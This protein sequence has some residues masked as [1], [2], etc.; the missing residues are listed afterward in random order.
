MLQHAPASA[1]LACTIVFVGVREAHA[2]V[3]PP[4][5]T[6]AMYDGAQN[7]ICANQQRVWIAAG[8]NVAVLDAVTGDR[9]GV[10]TYSPYATSVQAVEFDPLSGV[11]AVAT[12]RALNVI[13]PS[14]QRREWQAPAGENFPTFQ[15]V[16]LWPGTNK[17]FAI[18]GRKLA[19]FEYSSAGI[20]RLGETDC[21]TPDVGGLRRLHVQDV[22]GDLR[23]YVVAGLVGGTAPRKTALL[24]ADLDREHGY[25]A[26]SFYAADWRAHVVYSNPF[27]GARAVEV[28]PNLVGTQDVAFVADNYGELSVLDV[29]DPAQPVFV[30]QIHPAGSCGASGAAYNLLGERARNRLYVAGANR[31]Y[32]LQL[33]D[34]SIVGCADVEFVDAGR[35]DMALVRRRNGARILW[36]TTPHAATWSL[37]G[38]D[39]GAL[40]PSIARQG[41]WI[42]SSDGGVAAPQWHSIYLPTFGGVVRYELQQ[43]WNPQ[44]VDAS[45]RPSGFVTE[46]IEI[47]YPDPS[48]ASRAVLLTTPANGGVQVWPVSAAQPNPGA[49]VLWQGR[50]PSWNPSDAVY[51]N[52]IEPY[53][54]AGRTWALGD[55]T[56]NTTGEL[57]LQ[58]FDIATGETKSA[59]LPVGSLTPNTTDVGVAGN[60]ALVGAGGGVFIVRLDGLPN[61]L[62]LVGTQQIDLDQ[63]GHGDNV[64]AIA[65]NSAG[66]IVF[67]ATDA[68][69]AVGSFTF[70][71]TNGTLSGP[72]SSLH[73]AGYP[74]CVGRI[75]YFAPSSRLY[76]ASRSATLLELGVDVGGQLQLLSTWRDEGC[77]SDLQDAHVYDFGHGPRVLAVKNTEGFVL[78]NPVDGL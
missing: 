72:I 19:T 69:G 29:S 71:R 56:N 67:V 55:L 24:F 42:A 77:F 76:V 43:E 44:P 4:A 40:Q 23:A 34:L 33:S 46:H 48:D 63:D 68:P 75:R 31:I 9:L 64:S 5:I 21:P 66:D 49:P 26:P 2:Q 36:T 8:R 39:V 27:A 65:S 57:A 6:G 7:D 13:L 11:R 54:H 41:W 35:R 62:T 59:V 18:A 28:M 20:V 14:G 58:A 38:I 1:F 73:G 61:A 74:G 17:L 15:D 3:P 25:V 60:F 45:Y 51:Q 50:P 10:D 30:S 22:D 37:N 52:D 70:D 53:A 47:A 32:T 78:L 16:K 12:A